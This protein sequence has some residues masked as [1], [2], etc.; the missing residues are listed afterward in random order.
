MVGETAPFPSLLCRKIPWINIYA[1]VNHEKEQE[2]ISTVG[3][4]DTTPKITLSE[5]S[6]QK[7]MMEKEMEARVK[8]QYN[9]Y[10]YLVLTLF[11]S[12]GHIGHT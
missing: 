6:T 10:G 12:K 3:Q 4:N 1:E 8:R 5:F 11:L 7:E 2:M 9:L